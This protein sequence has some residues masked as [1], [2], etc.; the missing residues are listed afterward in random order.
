MRGCGGFL[1]PVVWLLCG[2]S[3]RAQSLREDLLRLHDDMGI[4]AAQDALASQG[5]LAGDGLRVAVIDN[6]FS[7]RH[8]GLAHLRDSGVVDSWDWLKDNREACD[9]VARKVH[10]SSTLGILASRWDSLPGVL[11]AAKWLLY[12]T[13]VDSF[14]RTSEE[15]W[16]AKAMDRAVDSGAQVISI[17]LGYRYGIEGEGDLS[18][19]L[20]DGWQR[21]ESRAARRA[22]ARGAVVVV[23]MGN[24]GLPGADGFPTLGAPADA[25]SILAV[26][27]VDEDGDRCYFS[28][29]GNAADGRIKPDLVAFGCPVPI[30]EAT[31]FTGSS[32]S[33]GTSF[34]T[35]LMAGAA[36]LLRQ[37]HPQWSVTEVIAALRRSTTQSAAPDSLRG[38]GMPDLRKLLTGTVPEPQALTGHWVRAGMQG[39]L[40]MGAMPPGMLECR[41]LRGRLLW[42]LP[43]SAV[44]A[45]Q[46]VTGLE[47]PHGVS[48]LRWRSGEL[49][50]DI[51][52]LL[53]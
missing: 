30:L 27:A 36:G 47:L 23:A 7:L 21:P 38:W 17:S 31:S 29:V 15:D 20:M 5:K 19:T 37:L 44:P 40:A 53:P 22:A 9:T 35:P 11:P 18:W 8:A 51:R 1:I 45:G 52:V 39:L 25:D 43:V 24:D 49:S 10:G 6:G 42:L 14:E 26:G 16:L 50:Q 34:A 3:G 41:D 13:E 33:G 12:R 32:Y 46:M 4:T 48:V 2:S 28:S